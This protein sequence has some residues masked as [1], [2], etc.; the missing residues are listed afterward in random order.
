MRYESRLCVNLERLLAS[1]ERMSTSELRLKDGRRRYETYLS[2]L[3]RYWREL[4]TITNGSNQ[5]LGE[6]RRKIEHL[7]DLVDD[8]KLRTGVNVVFQAQTHHQPNITREQANEE[9]SHYLLNANRV[10]EE[11]RRELVNKLGTP[12]QGVGDVSQRVGA[13]PLRPV[14]RPEGSV[15]SEEEVALDPFNSLG[16]LGAVSQPMGENI[17]QHT[18]ELAKL[19]KSAGF[20]LADEGHQNDASHAERFQ[21]IQRQLQET[22]IDETAQLAAEL[23]DRSLLSRKAIAADVTTLDSTEKVIA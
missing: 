16:R 12:V 23:R 21:Q 8:E 14:I 17:I 2:V 7:T 9:L 10:H 15:V 19:S 11:L 6:Y 1:C 5:N 13:L 4:A 22:L 3:Q 18:G 20:E